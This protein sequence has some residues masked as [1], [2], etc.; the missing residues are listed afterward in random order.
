MDR[1]KFYNGNKK[2]NRSVDEE[3]SQTTW[4]QTCHVLKLVF[5]VVTDPQDLTC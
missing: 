5:D 2:Q 1:R 4:D 3:E